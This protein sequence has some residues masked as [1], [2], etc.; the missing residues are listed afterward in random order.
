MQGEGRLGPWLGKRVNTYLPS[1]RARS[2]WK[3]MVY[4]LSSP[5]TGYHQPTVVL[6]VDE[7]MGLLDSVVCSQVHG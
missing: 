7:D 6:C 2:S 1:A 3:E 4:H 5:S